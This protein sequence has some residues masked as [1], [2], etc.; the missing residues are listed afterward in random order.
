[1]NMSC[2]KVTA[3]TAAKHAIFGNPSRSISTLSSICS[4]S[5]FFKVDKAI[6]PLLKEDALPDVTPTKKTSGYLPNI[7]RLLQDAAPKKSCISIE[8]TEVVLLLKKRK[9][10]YWAVWRGRSVI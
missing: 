4:N 8:P 5:S 6:I 3:M 2:Q 7:R 9:D 1:M 10:K